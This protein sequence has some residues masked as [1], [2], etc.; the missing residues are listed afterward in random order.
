MKKVARLEIEEFVFTTDSEVVPQRKALLIK[1]SLKTKKL[2]VTENS[3][4]TSYG[5]R[6]R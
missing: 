5:Y 6:A 2:K 1:N 4:C 3:F